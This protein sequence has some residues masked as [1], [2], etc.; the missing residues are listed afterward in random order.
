MRLTMLLRPHA[1]A[2]YEEAILPLAQKELLLALKKAFPTL[3]ES[4]FCIEYTPVCGAKAL[5]FCVPDDAGADGIRL[6]CGH[7]LIYFLCETTPEG[8]LKPVGGANEPLLGSDLSAVL[9]YK[10]KTNETFT[11]FLIRMALLSCKAACPSGSRIRLLDPMCGKGTTLFEAL[12]MGMDAFGGDMDA[13]AVKE[14]AQYYKKY[15]EYH[16]K[17][18]TQK[19]TGMTL[20]QGKNVPVKTIAA[21]DCG[22]ASF[23]VCDAAMIAAALGKQKAHIVV[24]DLPYGV[25]H[26]PAGG[27]TATLEGILRTTLPGIRKAMLPG[28]AIAL[29]FNTYTLP[30]ETVLRCL[31]EAGFTPV[32]GAEYE[33]M[34][35]FVEQAVMRDVCVALNPD[36]TPKG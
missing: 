23:A 32:E 20:P 33:N 26:G 4:S 18:H 6:L 34:E 7:S 29:S 21:A 1:N 3:D 19:E 31:G 12:N 14:A 27:R 30:R 24:C 25:Q 22:T 10:G 2:R 8:L 13:A 17:K 35:H 15:L 9:K 5:S 11:R 28:G 36:G 16:R